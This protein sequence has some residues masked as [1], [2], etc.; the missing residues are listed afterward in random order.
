MVPRR[1][2]KSGLSTLL[3]IFGPT[4]PMSF[5]RHASMLPRY[6][7]IFVLIAMVGIATDRAVGALP[8][9]GRKY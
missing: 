9:M 6:G 2:F 4:R 7:A 5:G 1:S 3:M 8:R